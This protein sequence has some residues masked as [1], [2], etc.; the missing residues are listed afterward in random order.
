LADTKVEAARTAFRPQVGVRAGFEADRQRFADRG[1]AN[2][3]AG[4]SVRF[5]LFNGYSDKARREESMQEAE[6]SR[7][8]EQQVRNG[9]LLDLRKAWL[10]WLSTG[11]RLAVTASTVSMAEEN[12]RIIKNRYDSGLTTVTELLRSETAL[13]DARFRKL[14]AIHDQR[15][16]AAVVEA[17]AGVLSASSEVLR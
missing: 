3:M 6:R 5:N 8:L 10:D 7:A 14:A 13:L 12:L 9:V 1:G 11:E 16:A 4:A 17:A 2:W 15:V